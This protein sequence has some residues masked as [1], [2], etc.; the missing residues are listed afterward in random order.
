MTNSYSVR[1]A[2][3]DHWLA[4]YEKILPAYRDLRIPITFQALVI[5]YTSRC[6][7]KCGMC[8]QAAGPKGSDLI[9][10]HALSL[11]DICRAIDSVTR[12]PQVGRRFHISG[13]EAF[14][15]QKKVLSAVEYAH[16][17]NHFV[18]ISVTT[19]G[20]WGITKKKAE[21]TARAA[22][23]AGMSM[24]EISWDVWHGPYITGHTLSNAI[25]G[26]VANGIEVYLRILT[27][28]KESAADALRKL[29]TSALEVV[30]AIHSAP[31][32]ST[33]RAITNIPRDEIFG[34]NNNTSGAP[35]DDW[36]INGA[37]HPNLNLTI[38]AR[39]D[40]F[41]CCAGIDQTDGLALWNIKN[42]SLEHIV[43]AM[44]GSRLYR[45]LV[46]K[47]VSS[48]MPLL[49]EAG[50]PVREKYSS[51]CEFC[52]DTFARPESASIVTDHFDR[53]AMQIIHSLLSSDN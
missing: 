18:D 16:K 39:G 32:M 27:T 2:A 6:N 7:A 46:F 23:E 31:V 1:P 19:N 53:E 52:Y 4:T 45:D 13:G 10:D 41:P 37:C 47:G 35:D 36:A 34:I 9:G 51:M 42:I 30:T 22:A 50:V 26:C 5:E 43:K 40:V 15:D 49:L 11:E 20:Y 25:E 17:K 24:M 12:L 14:L 8:Y 29:R 3:A 28:R 44:N 38:N 21:G 33:G 48:F